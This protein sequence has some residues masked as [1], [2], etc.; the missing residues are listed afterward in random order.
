[1]RLIKKMDV[2]LHFHVFVWHDLINC[3][4]HA[5]LLEPTLVSTPK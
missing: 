2:Y 4:F 5:N 1:M 3:G